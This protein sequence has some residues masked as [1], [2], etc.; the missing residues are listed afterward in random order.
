M[1][2]TFLLPAQQI[3]NYSTFSVPL[4]SN[5]SFTFPELILA[6]WLLFKG[7]IHLQSL[8]DLLNRLNQ[9]IVSQQSNINRKKE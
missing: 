2:H 3:R 4:G 5:S 7:S 9:I 1:V 8:Q 6:V